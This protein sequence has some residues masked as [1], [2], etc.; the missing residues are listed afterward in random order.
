MAIEI[1]KKAEC[2][3]KAKTCSGLWWK[4]EKG[5]SPT[6]F[7]EHQPGWTMLYQVAIEYRG[8]YWLMNVSHCPF[9]GTKLPE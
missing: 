6:N 1:V 3:D 5:N 8:M 4:D 7:P 9:C 2:C